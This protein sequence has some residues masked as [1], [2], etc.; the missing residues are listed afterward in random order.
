[1]LADPKAG[2]LVDNFAGQ[3]LYL[4]NLDGFVPNSVGFPNFDDNLRQGLRQETELFF[5]SIVEE[6]RSVVDLM[7]ADYTFLNERVAQAL[8]RAG[9]LRAALPASRAR[10]RTAL[11]A[12]RARAAC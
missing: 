6:D 3:W 4:R 8:W 5:A 9:C 2:A 12:A 7:T 10:G 11:G 1:M